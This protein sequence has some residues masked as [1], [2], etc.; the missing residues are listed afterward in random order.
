VTGEA[1]GVG[2][3]TVRVGGASR[4][5][6]DRAA[7]LLSAGGAG[8][9]EPGKEMRGEIRIK[10]RIR[11]SHVPRCCRVF[12]ILTPDIQTR[13]HNNKSSPSPVAGCVPAP[14]SPAAAFSL[15]SSFI[16]FPCLPSLVAVL[17]SPT[18]PSDN[19]H[20]SSNPPLLVVFV[21]R[22]GVGAIALVVPPICMLLVLTPPT[23]GF[24][25]AAVGDNGTAFPNSCISLSSLWGRGDA[26]KKARA[27]DATAMT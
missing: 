4:E 1:S 24:A 15:C 17:S 26:G 13:Y 18:E 10:I 27:G 14:Q 2:W 8:G 6:L 3:I 25:A 5:S 22:I 19:F 16:L 11:L 20:K 9:I 12:P 21:A 23:A 7:L